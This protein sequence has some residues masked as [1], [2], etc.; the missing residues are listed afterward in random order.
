MDGAGG[1]G[2]IMATPFSP[3][4]ADRSAVRRQDGSQ[5]S[6]SPFNPTPADP[7]GLTQSASTPTPEPPTVISAA[8]PKSHN[9]DAKISAALAGKKLGHFELIETVGAGGMGA[10]LRARDLDLGRIV[11]LKIL[12]PDLAAEPENIIRFK[13]EAR[14]AAKLDHDNIARVYFFGEDQGLHF[15]AFEFVEGDNL[16]QLMDANGGTIPVADAI[17]LMLQVSAGLAHAAER[18]VVHRDIKPSNIIVTP[19]GRAKIVDM[20]LA[21]SLDARSVGQLT[22][23]GVMLGTFDYISPE[24]ANEPRSADVRS[25]IYSLGC[26]FYHALTGH[27]PV[28]EGTA[29]KKLDAQKNLM[30]P[31]P[32][33]YNPAIPADLAAVLSRMMAKDPSRRYQDPAHLSAHLRSVA[34]KLGIPTGPIPTHGPAFED[35]LPAAPKMSAAWVLTAVA[36]MALLIAIFVNTFGGRQQVPPI[37]DIPG[38]N[39]SE[40]VD[41]GTYGP[42]AAGARDAANEEE[43]L[44]LL[45][46]GAKNIRLTGLEYDLVHYRDRDGHP[47][48]AVLAGDDVRLDGLAGATVKLGYVPTD[49]KIRS[50]TLTLRGPGTGR[51]FLRKI[52]FILPEKDGDVGESGLVIAGFD[53]VTV[54]DCT[55]TA[56][57][58]RTVQKG[59]AALAVALKGGI[60]NLLRCY[61]APGCVGLEV[62]GPGKMTATECAIAPQHAGVRV[63]RSAADA[64]GE[65]E[66]N[67]IHCSALLTPIGAVVELDDGV[68]CVVRAGHC[69]FA[70]PERSLADE[71]P[72]VLRQRKTRAPSTRYEGDPEL[73]SNGYYHIAAYAEGESTYSFADA[74]REKLPISDVEKP[75]KHPWKDR[76]PQKLLLE[77]KPADPL[78]AFKQDLR[79]ADLRGKDDPKGLLLGANFVGPDRLYPVPLPSPDE[80]RDATVKIWDPSLPETAEDLPP[81]VYPTLERALA[82]VRSGDTLLIRHTGRLP[83]NEHEFQKKDFS[84]TI[85]PDAGF[86]PILV[87][88]APG[89]KKPRGIFVLF[90]GPT[91]KL[92]LDGLHFRLP[93]DRAPSVAVLPGGGQLEIRNSVITIE[94]GDDPAAITLTEPRGEMMMM[95]GGAVP[96]SWP[97]PKVTLENVFIRGKG[98]LLNVKGSRPFELELKNVLAALDDSLIDIDPSTADPSLYGSGIVRLTH[99]TTY[100]AGSLLHFRASERKA[101]MGPTGLARTEITA[102]GCVFTPAGSALETFVRADRLDST[103]QAEK[104]FSFHGKNN[105]YGYDKKKVMLELRPADVDAMPVKL[106][107]GDRWLAMTLEPADPDPFA[108]V[109]FEYEKPVAGDSK[110]FIGIRPIDFRVMRFEPVRPEGAT[111]VGAANDLPMPFPDE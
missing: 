73:A 81:G 44:S 110:R 63:S 22:E 82:A 15:I 30:P 20:G 28:P 53:R 99:V 38:N 83:V 78:L 87:P 60:A 32:R 105:V 79:L 9:L 24:Q 77:S 52:R 72:V 31:D 86:K 12:P 101:E 39:G 107:E 94:E 69:L 47:V 6:T 59:P 7:D 71:S 23:S 13:Q 4:P 5:P 18:S 2:P 54:E 108:K 95:G 97:L 41:L 103:E 16:R 85:K 80:S 35:P 48:D 40:P 67:L 19:D 96:L 11:A 104:W 93:A 61:F 75:L 26:T 17:A 91:N 74:A 29:A 88:A 62:D 43:L 42:V 68:P 10:V 33:G 37:P 8:R 102:S 76:D 36:V 25:D 56:T 111:E 3:N 66:L 70:G 21:R 58:Q 84:L 46:Q 1:D 100:L 45:R 92:V 106:I 27:P 55:F 34:R 50:K 57:G 49:G 65:T 51:A 90:G 64:V 14:A 109:S 89:L 98:R